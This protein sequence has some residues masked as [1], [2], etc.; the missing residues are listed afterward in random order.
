MQW[1]AGTIWIMLNGF[2]PMCGVQEINISSLSC[3]TPYPISTATRIIVDQDFI[4][5]GNCAFITAAPSFSS[6]VEFYTA[7]PRTITVDTNGIWDLTSFA[8]AIVKFSGQTIVKLKNGSVIKGNGV[9][10][11]FADQSTLTQSPST[12]GGGAG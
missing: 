8:T 1:R 4:L 3:D 9:H 6:T 12:S 2:L 5:T 10:I 7:T 11:I